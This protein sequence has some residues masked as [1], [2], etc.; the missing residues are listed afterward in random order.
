MG[1]ASSPDQWDPNSWKMYLW[2]NPRLQG[3]NQQPLKNCVFHKNVTQAF[4]VT[5][6]VPIARQKIDGPLILI[7]S[8]IDWY[9]Q[10]N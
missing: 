6:K 9:V 1:S 4:G 7:D 3:I 2:V 8:F 10:Y 5:M